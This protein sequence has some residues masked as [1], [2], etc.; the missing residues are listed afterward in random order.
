MFKYISSKALIL[1]VILSFLYFKLYNAFNGLVCNFNESNNPWNF[2]LKFVCYVMRNLTE[3]SKIH[4]GMLCCALKF[5]QTNTRVQKSSKHF[6]V[7]RFKLKKNPNSI[8]CKKC[9]CINTY[10]LKTVIDVMK[11]FFFL[12]SNKFF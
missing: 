5:E 7:K 6:Y 8:L 4:N 1:N 11:H 3:C 12:V 2:K 10:V 9:T